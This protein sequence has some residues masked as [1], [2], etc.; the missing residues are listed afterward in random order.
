MRGD[1]LKES[2]KVKRYKRSG[3]KKFNHKTKNNNV[4]SKERR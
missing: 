4:R 2:R 1:V 3:N